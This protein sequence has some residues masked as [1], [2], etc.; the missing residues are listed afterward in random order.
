[1]TNDKY[2][3]PNNFIYDNVFYDDDNVSLMCGIY[4][5]AETYSLGMRWNVS[6]SELGYPNIFGKSMW[7][8]VPDKIAA[9]ILNGILNNQD[10]TAFID[11]ALATK[12]FHI[13]KKQI[14]VND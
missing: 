13:I 11:R 10:D 9:Y 14:K 2:P 7:M 4:K 1:M 5:D 12:Y 6:E 8:V 3:R